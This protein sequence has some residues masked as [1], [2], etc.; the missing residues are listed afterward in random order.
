MFAIFEINL[1]SERSCDATRMHKDAMRV[2]AFRIDLRRIV[3]R[4]RHD[5]HEN[6]RTNVAHDM[7]QRD[8]VVARR[9][10]CF[11]RRACGSPYRSLRFAT[12]D[13]SPL[14]VTYGNC[15]F[16]GVRGAHRFSTRPRETEIRLQ[17]LVCSL[18][19]LKAPRRCALHYFDAATPLRPDTLE[20][21]RERKV[22]PKRTM[23]CTH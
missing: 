2:H 10:A 7:L 19:I 13:S 14:E 8:N 17:A 18:G 20:R 22:R 11:N 23:P 1:K 9:D 3:R 16:A 4:G 15:R 21:E 6:G 5:V 12:G